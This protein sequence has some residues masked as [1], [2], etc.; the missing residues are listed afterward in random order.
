M[1]KEKKFKNA[2][3]SGTGISGCKFTTLFVH[4]PWIVQEP[5]HF[6]YQITFIWFESNV[7]RLSSLLIVLGIGIQ[8]E[9][10]LREE[11]VVELAFAEI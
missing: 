7:A 1:S 8:F 4:Y 5:L 2:G 6:N 3:S 11:I 10:Q 9:R